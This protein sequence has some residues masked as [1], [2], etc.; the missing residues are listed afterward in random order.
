[1]KSS[2]TPWNNAFFDIYVYPCVLD[3]SVTQDMLDMQDIFRPVVSH[4]ALPMSKRLKVDRVESWIV[5]FMSKPFAVTH[6][7]VREFI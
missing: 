7:G 3:I 5:N 1:M 6:K 4:C 2:D